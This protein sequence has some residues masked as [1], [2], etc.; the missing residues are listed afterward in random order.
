MPQIGGT[1][2]C[3]EIGG[4]YIGAGESIT[5]KIPWQDKNG[6][7]SNDRGLSKYSILARILHHEYECPYDSYLSN[8]AKF[9]VLENKKIAQNSFLMDTRI[10]FRF[11]S[12]NRAIKSVDL[13][14][15]SSIV[16]VYLENQAPEGSQL[17]VV[18]VISGKECLTADI[19]GKQIVEVDMTTLP[20]G[21]YCLI[22]CEDARNLDQYIV[23]VP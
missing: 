22:Y 16:K 4:T 8:G 7:I 18:S 14:E 10:R 21:Q 1:V 20:A 13:S 11:S 5:V 9:Y 3:V 23:Q 19:D 15:L 17:R 6:K 2:G 12:S